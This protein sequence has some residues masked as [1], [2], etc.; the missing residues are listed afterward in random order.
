MLTAVHTGEE[1]AVAATDVVGVTA[2]IGDANVLG[3]GNITA[4]T[5]RSAYIGSHHSHTDIAKLHR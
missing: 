1:A 2:V 3:G 4:S 5:L